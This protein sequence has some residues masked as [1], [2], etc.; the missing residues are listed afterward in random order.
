VLEEEVLIWGLTKIEARTAEKLEIAKW[1]EEQLLNWTKSERLEHMDRIRLD[2]NYKIGIDRRSNNQ[3]WITNNR[4]QL[5]S[6]HSTMDYKALGERNR[7]DPVWQ[8]KIK[9]H[10]SSLNASRRKV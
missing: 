2:P 7:A 3:N 6:L 10:L 9:S 5:S 8:E 4:E 1:P